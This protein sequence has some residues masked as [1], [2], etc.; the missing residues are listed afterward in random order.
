LMGRR[1]MRRTSSRQYRLTA[2]FSR[3]WSGSDRTGN[4]LCSHALGRVC[5]AARPQSR[6]QTVNIKFPVDIENQSGF[7]WHI[8]GNEAALGRGVS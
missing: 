6:P 5:G 2:L 3:C 1:R 7:R 8:R 4:S